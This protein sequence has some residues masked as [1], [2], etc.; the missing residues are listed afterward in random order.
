MY[1]FCSVRWSTYLERTSAAHSKTI[2]Y[3]YL[4]FFVRSMHQFRRKR[5]NSPSHW[6][7]I[8]FV[9]DVQIIVCLKFN[10][11]S[12]KNKSNNFLNWSHLHMSQRIYER[13]RKVN[14]F[15]LSTSCDANQFKDSSTKCTAAGSIY[16]K[17]ALIK[18]I[19][20]TQQIHLS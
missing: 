9:E 13:P 10:R 14:K 16:A 12:F 6:H 5:K 20:I 15:Y 3:H 18:H 4:F 11:I 7:I 17:H 2:N 1:S 8:F 19:R